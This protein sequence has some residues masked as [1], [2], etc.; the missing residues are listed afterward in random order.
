[1]QG[2]ALCQP[3]QA[4][5]RG[6]ILVSGYTDCGICIKATH[7]KAEVYGET[8]RNL[9]VFSPTD[10]LCRIGKVSS[11]R[12][13]SL[14]IGKK[15]IN[16]FKG[17]GI[18]GATCAKIYEEKYITLPGGFVLPIAIGCETVITY[19]SEV[20]ELFVDS[21]L[22]EFAGEYITDQMTSGS[23]LQSEQTIQ[24]LDG[25]CRLDGIYRCYEIIGITRVEERIAQYE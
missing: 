4:V 17:S 7:A 12:K 21:L 8:L 6:Q 9:T 18:S 23:V 2:S 22:S 5:K 3:G 20:Q 10:Y 24:T 19:T 16:F 15:R 1:M 25:Y 14:V 13:Y 11:S